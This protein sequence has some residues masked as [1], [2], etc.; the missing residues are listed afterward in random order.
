[1][2]QRIKHKVE[3]LLQ[4]RKLKRKYRDISKKSIIK[5]ESFI[6]KNSE[7]IVLCLLKNGS[8][9]IDDFMSHYLSLGFK[10]FVF[11]DN[12]S[13]D[14]SIEKLKK[15]DVTILSC[16][17][18]YKD[19]KYYYKQYLVKT[20]AVKRWSLYVDVDEL[21]EYP[22]QSKINLKQF[23][24]YLDTYKYNAV[25]SIMVDMFADIPLKDLETLLSKPLK[26][27]YPYYDNSD[28]VIR[29]YKKAYNNINSSQTVHFRGGIHK[30]I[31]GISDIYLSKIPL[32]KWQPGIKVHESSHSS[33]FVNIADVSTV[34]L[35]YKFVRGFYKKIQR[36]IKEKNYWNASETYLK[37]LKHIEKNPLLNLKKASAKKYSSS[38]NLQDEGTVWVSESYKKYLDKI[39]EKCVE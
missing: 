19:Y 17:L 9:F 16:K 18:P 20:F 33:T 30:Q 25:M 2:I 11:I 13:E 23:L 38:E 10:H 12:V 36:V 21:W 31:F 35:H 8:S 29:P 6:P 27:A 28:I 34:L 1:M 14:N 3:I 15:Y 7:P 22:Y 26:E 4:A 39:V 32:V 5:K 24:E 37:Y